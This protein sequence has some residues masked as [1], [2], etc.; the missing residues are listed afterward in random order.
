MMSRLE[1]AEGHLLSI[2][3]VS[4]EKNIH[5]RQVLYHEA[6]SMTALSQHGNKSINRTGKKDA[7]IASNVQ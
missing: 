1:H 4:F 7:F 6:K 2:D 3:F 5:V